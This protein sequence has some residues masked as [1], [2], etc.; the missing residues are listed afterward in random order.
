M[1]RY[2]QGDIPSP[3]HLHPYRRT[4]R[5]FTQPH[6]HT[7]TCSFIPSWPRSNPP[8]FSVPPWYRPVEM[9]SFAAL[10]GEAHWGQRQ[11]I[12]VQRL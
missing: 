8:S 2:K 11:G 12:R 9:H 1:Q 6:K 5:T 7:R 4:D 3:M 10:R